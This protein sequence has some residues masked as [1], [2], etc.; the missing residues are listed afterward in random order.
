LAKIIIVNTVPQD[1]RTFA[2][3]ITLDHIPDDCKVYCFVF[4]SSDAD[5]KTK[6]DLEELGTEYGNNLFT[7]FWSMADPNYKDIATYFDLSTLPTIVMTAEASLASTKDSNESVFVRLDNRKLLLDVE[8][9]KELVRL[10]YNL[11][12]T[13]EVANAIRTAKNASR[14]GNIRDISAKVEKFFTD[15]LVKIIEKYNIDF[16]FGPFNVT[17]EK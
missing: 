15:T 1:R 12:I 17:L 9:V 2:K 8:N 7:G 6:K 14:W 13:G 4:G 16:S 11:F 10:L 3:S 5:E